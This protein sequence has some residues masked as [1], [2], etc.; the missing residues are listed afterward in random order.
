MTIGAGLFA[1]VTLSWL[2]MRLGRAAAAKPES[3]DGITRPR[4]ER[5]AHGVMVRPTYACTPAFA[6]TAAHFL[7][8]HRPVDQVCLLPPIAHILR[9]KR[10]RD[11]CE[12]L[13]NLK[14]RTSHLYS[15]S[16]RV[17]R[18]TMAI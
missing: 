9:L 12:L 7:L 16:A 11:K 1:F 17:E 3:W 5:M 14:C 13:T 8:F 10:S 6:H 18:T 15:R 2:P 4:S